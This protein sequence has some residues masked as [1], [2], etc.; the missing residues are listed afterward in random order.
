MSE[1]S[2]YE[3]DDE[4]RLRVATFAD[5]GIFENG[6]WT[7]TGVRQ[8]V[9]GEDGVIAR[10]VG[11]ADW[12]SRFRPELAEVVS[13]RLASLSIPGL[14]QYI[15]YL[16]SNE[17]DTARFELALWKKF[18]HPFTTVVMIFIALPLVLGRLGSVGIAQ[19]I[20]AG[21]VISVG[22][23]VIE[24]LSGHMGLAL[25]VSP[26]VAAVA[27]TLLFAALAGWLFRRVG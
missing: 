10:S 26:G 1:L 12:R 25:G 3:F 23:L 11:E 19:R 18:V 16:K 5:R 6:Q 14:M 13:V 8:S 21:V 7:L 4:H 24:Q 22:F 20:L 2:I 27:P 9:I 15:D 17:L